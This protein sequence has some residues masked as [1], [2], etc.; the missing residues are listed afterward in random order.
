V[1]PRIRINSATVIACLL[2][3]N[4][5]AQ[6]MPTLTENV[7][8]TATSAK[9]IGTEYHAMESA[10]APRHQCTS[11]QRRIQRQL[12][13]APHH[14]P[15]TISPGVS[16]VVSKLSSVSRSRSAAIDRAA[17]KLTRMH[18][19]HAT[20]VPA[21]FRNTIVYVAKFENPLSSRNRKMTQA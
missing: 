13:K 17:C 1:V 20:N 18:S 10:T 9:R 14:L 11:S 4:L 2:V 3:W 8:N 12:R 19:K 7:A 15:D 6:N 21:S 16:A 5:A